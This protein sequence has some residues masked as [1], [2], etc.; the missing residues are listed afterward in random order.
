MSML[1][2]GIPI[3]RN[4]F[5]MPIQS[6]TTFNQASITQEIPARSI[7]LHPKRHDESPLGKVEIVD[8]TLIITVDQLGP[9]FVRAANAI[10]ELALMPANWDSYGSPPIQKHAVESALRLLGIFDVF[11][12]PT[13]HVVPVS[14]GAL[15]LE[16]YAEGRVLE[17]A[18]HTNGTTDY[19]AVQDADYDAAEEGIINH[20]DISI[21]H[22][23]V[24]WLA[25]E[26]PH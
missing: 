20:R 1:F 24:K 19:L 11:S 13:P 5:A 18:V 12:F 26:L 4:P 22:H 15:Q 6:T 2:G 3:D 25:E 21:A 16:W 14:G 10:H 8:D 17:V 7:E 23:L 9:R